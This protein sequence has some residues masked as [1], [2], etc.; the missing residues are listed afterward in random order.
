MPYA[1]RDAFRGPVAEVCIS[2]T[3]RGLAQ[4]PSLHVVSGVVSQGFSAPEAQLRA[5][6][7]SGTV[8]LVSFGSKL[9]HLRVTINEEI[10]SI[11]QWREGPRL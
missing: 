8:R 3:V 2:F 10:W 9:V 7:L 11:I 6:L 5:M 1:L 4:L